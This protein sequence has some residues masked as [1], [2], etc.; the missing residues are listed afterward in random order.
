MA[1]PQF[2]EA[3]VERHRDDIA[4]AALEMVEQEGIPNLTLRRLATRLGC[5][6][7]KPYSYYRNKEQLLDAVRGRG[8]D[9]LT[10]FAERE[11]ATRGELVADFYLRFASQNPETYRVM[12]ALDQE[13]VSDETQSKQERAWK[14]CARPIHDMVEAGELEGDADLIAHVCWSALHGLASLALSNQL[15]LGKSVE[16][17]GAALP[18]I[19]DAFRPKPGKSGNAQ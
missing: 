14:A 5:S 18:R 6:Y 12:F 3:E 10:E 2:S 9:L 19:F 4:A 7:T 1:R 8:F 15:R 13:Y 11:I 17:V 16:E